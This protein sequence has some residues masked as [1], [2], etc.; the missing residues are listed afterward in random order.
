MKKRKR[1]KVGSSGVLSPDGRKRL[2]NHRNASICTLVPCPLLT[3]VFSGLGYLFPPAAQPSGR[4]SGALCP[5]SV[6]RAPCV[7][8]PHV[9]ITSSAPPNSP[10][11]VLST[12]EPLIRLACSRISDEWS[13]IICTLWSLPTLIQHNSFP[14][15]WCCLVYSWSFS[16]L[17]SN[18]QYKYVKVCLFTS[19]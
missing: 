7:L 4:F 15:H 14:N 16:L 10:P 12:K 6:P 11:R 3:P 13:H 5:W 19:L 18:S 2:S 1:Q 17:R 9:W 8:T